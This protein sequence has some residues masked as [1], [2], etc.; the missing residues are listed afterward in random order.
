MHPSERDTSPTIGREVL[1]VVPPGWLSRGPNAAGTH[2]RGVMSGLRG[3]G[4]RVRKLEAPTRLRGKRLPVGRLLDGLVRFSP[5]FFRRMTRDAAVAAGSLLLARRGNK[6]VARRRPDVIYERSSYLTMTGWRLAGRYGIPRV[7]EVNGLNREILQFGLKPGVLPIA[8]AFERMNL[9]TADRIVTVTEAM[10]RAICR[11]GVRAE[12]VHV[13]SCAAPGD[14]TYADRDRD[15]FRRQLGLGDSAVLGFVGH[16]LPWHGVEVLFQAL[17]KLR[18]AGDVRALIVGRLPRNG[19]L[20][21]LAR[22]RGLAERVTF[23]PPVPHGEL[24]AY[25]SC[26]DICVIPQHGAANSP[27]KLFEYGAARRPIIAPAI[28]GILEAWTPGIHGLGIRNG[29]SA[30]LAAAVRR[31]LRDPALA[32]EHANAFHREVLRKHTWQHVAERTA[33]ILRSTIGI[34]NGASPSTF[35][36]SSRPGR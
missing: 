36:N 29:R 10:K 28:E 31:Y 27:V 1:Y 18:D 30:D 9:Q 21:A 25:L 19:E 17:G 32:R 4:W 8:D 7:L 6:L 14:W 34:A 13:V 22:E 12:R 26:M 33:S 15:R 3:L 5:P 23:L 16:V 24:P 2:M 20:Q 11:L 35:T